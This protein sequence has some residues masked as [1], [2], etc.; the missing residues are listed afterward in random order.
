MYLKLEDLTELQRLI[1]HHDTIIIHRHV[2]PD[3]DALGSQLGLKYL[4]E[5]TYP[6]KSIYAVGYVSKGLRWMGPMDEIDDKVYEDALVIVTDTANTERLADQR[7]KLG[8]KIVKIDHH[9]VVEEYGDLQIVHTQASSA[10]EIIA[11]IA[12]NLSPKLLM[13][14]RAANLIFAGI[15]GDTNRFLYDATSD[16]TFKAAARLM[17]FNLKTDYIHNQFNTISAEQAKF[18]GHILNTLEIKNGVA[19]IRISREDLERFNIT[20]E[21]TN[22]VV[23]LPGTIEGVLAW[24]VYIEQDGNKDYW[25]LR[26]RSKGPVINK[27]AEKYHGGGHPKASGARLHSLEEKARFLE[28]LEELTLNYSKEQIENPEGL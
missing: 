9:P 16:V 26:V 28:E 24:V 3:P 12:E 19:T 14:D 10:S 20:E 4:L 17:E 11:E 8:K 25:R 5:N 18:Q 7:Y 21:D 15:V 27:L 6:D 2:R 1:E 22:S 13:T 23:T